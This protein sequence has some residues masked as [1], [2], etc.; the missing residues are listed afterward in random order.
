[1]FYKHSLS[2]VHIHDRSTDVP[3]SR[4]G[5]VI[6]WLKKE[7]FVYPFWI[8]KLCEPLPPVAPGTFLHLCNAF[9]LV[10]GFLQGKRSSLL[11]SSLTWA[12]ESCGVKLLRASSV[13]HSAFRMRSFQENQ[14]KRGDGNVVQSFWKQVICI[15]NFFLFFCCFLPILIDSEQQLWCA[16]IKVSLLNNVCI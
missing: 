5:R 3:G 16:S 9:E 8:L 7:E 2:A 14:R 10:M 6:E 11:S 12:G 15:N 1:M 13:T 4:Q